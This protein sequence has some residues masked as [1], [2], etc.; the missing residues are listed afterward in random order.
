MPWVIC[1]G[2]AV[3]RVLSR[4]R[5]QIDAVV[6][7]ESEDREIAEPRRDPRDGNVDVL[8]HRRADG[9]LNRQIESRAG[10]R[11]RVPVGPPVPVGACSCLLNQ[12]G[13][14]RRRYR[15][16]RLLLGNRGVA[17]MDRQRDTAQGAVLVTRIPPCL[18]ICE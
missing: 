16:I 18:D 6:G 1:C 15:G 11:V 12:P 9:F 5:S 2:K 8:L 4:C 14:E 3:A 7:F 17:M 10:R 13:R